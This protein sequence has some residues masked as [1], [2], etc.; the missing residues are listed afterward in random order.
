MV[1]KTDRV[2]TPGWP[3]CMLAAKLTALWT[4]GNSGRTGHIEAPALMGTGSLYQEGASP[5]RTYEPP[6]WPQGVKGGTSVMTPN[7]MLPTVLSES[8]NF[9]GAGGGEDFYFRLIAQ[10]TKAHQVWWTFLLP[11]W[12]PSAH[13]Q[14]SLSFWNTVGFK[15]ANNKT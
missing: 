8:Q 15:H 9:T 5:G 11:N 7:K 10:G 1:T 2:A 3:L 13:S 4:S 12:E 14:H 6:W